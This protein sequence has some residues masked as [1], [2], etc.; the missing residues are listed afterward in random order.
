MEREIER[1]GAKTEQGK[2]YVIIVYLTILNA[3][4]FDKPGAMAEGRKRYATSKGLHVNIGNDPNTFEIVETG[5]MVTR[6]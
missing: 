2:R 3:G 5:E 1:F 6:V 4:G